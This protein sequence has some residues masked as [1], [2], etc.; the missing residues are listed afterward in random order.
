LETV[1]WQPSL[2]TS[3]KQFL[4]DCLHHSVFCE[5]GGDLFTVG[6]NG[7]KV[8]QK[9]LRRQSWVAFLQIARS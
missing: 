3:S 1:G 7:K 4:G 2:F 5:K 6:D 8:E 9:F